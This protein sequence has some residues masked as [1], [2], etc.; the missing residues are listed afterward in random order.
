M[1]NPFSTDIDEKELVSITSGMEVESSVANGILA[2]K[3]IGENQFLEFCN[4]NLLSDKPDNFK[5]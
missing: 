4:K 3:E 5:N 2:A 1:A